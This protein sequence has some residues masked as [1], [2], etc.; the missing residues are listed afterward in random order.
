MAFRVR[1]VNNN[2][3]ISEIGEPIGKSLRESL[4]IRGFKLGE[5]RDI[6]QLRLIYYS[7]N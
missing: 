5:K 4:M 3:A 1:D 7:N 6:R 2:E